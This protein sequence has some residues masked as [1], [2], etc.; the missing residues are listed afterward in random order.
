MALSVALVPFGWC[1]NGFDREELKVGDIRDFGSNTDGLKAIKMI[2]DAAD[3]VTITPSV[4]PTVDMPSYIPALDRGDQPE[5][6]LHQ[7]QMTVEPP[8]V[9]DSLQSEP[10]IA[11]PA[12]EAPVAAPAKVEPAKSTPKRKRR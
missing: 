10:V 9:A 7:P 2:G 1:S 6:A 4:A 11:A 3:A 5:Y 8:A 12:S